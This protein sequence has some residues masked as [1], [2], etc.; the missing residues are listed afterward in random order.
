MSGSDD[1]WFDKEIDDFVVKTKIAE[2]VEDISSA[3]KDAEKDADLASSTA[4]P[5]SG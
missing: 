1:D 3:K 4:D 2:N 5:F